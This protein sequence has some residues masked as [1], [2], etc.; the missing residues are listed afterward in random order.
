MP[1][2]SL[3]EPERNAEVA[4]LPV[5]LSASP[6]VKSLIKQ[7][8]ACTVIDRELHFGITTFRGEHLRA[9]LAKLY[10]LPDP[11]VLRTVTIYLYLKRRLVREMQH[12]IR[13]GWRP[14][15]ADQRLP[16]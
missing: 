9:T 3:L 11:R 13:M 5:A 14:A 8:D 4:L 16:H 1:P 15:H 6:S 2:F 12:D 10:F 7:R